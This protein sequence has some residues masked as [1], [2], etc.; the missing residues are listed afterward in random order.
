MPFMGR[1]SINIIIKSQ[2]NGQT[3]VRIPSSGDAFHYNDFSAA[4]VRECRVLAIGMSLNEFCSVVCARLK[5]FISPEITLHRHSRTCIRGRN[6]NP[7]SR[8]TEANT[9]SGILD[10]GIAATGNRNITINSLAREAKISGS[11]TATA[12][13]HLRHI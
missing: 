8:V 13:C 4:R 10:S 2:H 11:P 6:E 7:I 9:H 5:E 3:T 1:P 12:T